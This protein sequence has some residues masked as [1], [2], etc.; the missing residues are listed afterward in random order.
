MKTILTY[1]TIFTLILVNFNLKADNPSI[2]NG[3]VYQLTVKS[4][5]IKKSRSI[6]VEYPY[7]RKVMNKN[8]YEYQFGKY[9]NYKEVD[10]V[11]TL[12]TNV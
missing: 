2:P 4:V 7:L 6:I 5:D 8:S 1:T 10:S 9:S 3:I 12:L 11:K